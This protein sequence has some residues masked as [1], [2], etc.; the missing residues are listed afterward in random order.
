MESTTKRSQWDLQNLVPPSDQHLEFAIQSRISLVHL[1]ASPACLPCTCLEPRVAPRCAAEPER[2]FYL[3]FQQPRTAAPGD[4]LLVTFPP[5]RSAPLL[6]PLVSGG[7]EGRDLDA[8][9]PRLTGWRRRRCPKIS[10]HGDQTAD[11]STPRLLCRGPAL[12]VCATCVWSR[13]PPS[14]LFYFFSN[15]ELGKQH[16]A[17]PVSGP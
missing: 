8:L 4:V 12:F 10:P 1:G 11:L 5:L 9:Q 17:D 2:N 16:P 14:I 3:D 15:L 13:R 6:A 7:G